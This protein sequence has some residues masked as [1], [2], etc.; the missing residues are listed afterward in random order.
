MRRHPIGNSFPVLVAGIA[1]AVTLTSCGGDASGTTTEDKVASLATTTGSTQVDTETPTGTP[2]DEAPVADTFED[3]Q[4]L[5]S[6]CM[7]DGGFEDFP[8]PTPGATGGRG[9][10]ADLADAGIDFR[11]EE[12]RH[13]MQECS[14][15]FEGVVGQREG[16][17]PEEQ[18]EREDTQLALFECA[19][20]N[21][22]PD[23]P[24]PDFGNG[25][26]TGGAFRSLADSGIDLRELRDVLGACSTELG[27]EQGA[28]P[29][30]GRPLAGAGGGLG[31]GRPQAGGPGQ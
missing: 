15:V 11:D 18:A 2:S 9:Q 19:R 6:Q 27:L 7:R 31:G 13:A 28:G 4:L 23:L 26:S 22:F 29:G 30:G 24:D 3:A 10:F 21:G 17:S 25:Q 14:S 20:R 16:L 8:D 5:F 12:V 1:L